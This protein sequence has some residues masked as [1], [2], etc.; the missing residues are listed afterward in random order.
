MSYCELF[1]DLLSNFDQYVSRKY[2]LSDTAYTRKGEWDLETA[3]KYPICSNKKTKFEDVN[4]FLKRHKSD[5]TVSITGSGVCDRMQYIDPQ[6][7]IDMLDDSVIKIY[8][9]E[10]MANFKGKIIAAIDSS[11]LDISNRPETKR[12]MDIPEDTEFKKYDAK[13]RLSCMVDGLSD[14]VISANLSNLFT[15]E[16]THALWHLDDAK[17]KINLKNVITTYDRFYNSQELMVKTMYYESF[18]VIRGKTSTFKDEQKYMKRNNLTDATFKINLTESLIKTFRDENLQEFAR[19]LGRMEIRIVFVKL[20]TGETEILFTN[21]DK[22]FATP[23]DLKDMYGDRWT[24]ETDFDRLKN[25]LYIEKFT[26]RRKV[27]IEQD[28]YSHLFIFNLLMGIKHDA[29][30][31]ITRKPRK[32]AKYKYAYHSNVNVLIGEIK[33][34]LPD[35]LRC[36]KNQITNLINEI[37]NIGKKEIV[38]TKI[39]AP[40]NNERD[41]TDFRTTNCPSNASMGF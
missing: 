29:E 35:L 30:S 24:V 19:N 41:K 39:P 18:F 37:I 1:G 33:D 34:R 10:K 7:Y 9:N 17:N 8:E 40:T 27:I 6:A 4:K 26:G 5:L 23:K 2:V 14:F 13:A 31:K 32:T 38:A 15:D 12:E 16:I 36:N 20:K 28:C 25:K 22:K 3:I 21:L 11:Q